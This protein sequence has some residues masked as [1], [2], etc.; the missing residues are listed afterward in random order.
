MM[1]P[2]AVIGMLLLSAWAIHKGQEFKPQDLGIGIGAI[3]GGLGAMKWGQSTEK[4]PDSTE[5]TVVST[6]STEKPK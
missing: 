3:L 1:V 5:V 4:R 6:T 2:V